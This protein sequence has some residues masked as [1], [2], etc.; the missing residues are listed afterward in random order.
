MS[1]PLA[2]NPKRFY[3]EA[4]VCSLNP[5]VNT[6]TFRRKPMSAPLTLNPKPLTLLKGS[7]CQLPKPFK[8][9]MGLYNKVPF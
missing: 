6:L 9:T 4:D 8:G 3:K 2:L 1:A 7:R 5:T